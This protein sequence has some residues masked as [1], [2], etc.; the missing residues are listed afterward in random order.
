MGGATP[1]IS[2]IEKANFKIMAPHYQR[3]PVTTQEA[4]H[5]AEFFSKIDPKAPV[6]ARPAIDMAGT[7]LAGLFL[8][9]LTVFLRW[10]RS[11]R[12]RD[13]K[14]TRRRK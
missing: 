12:G 5:L 14:L 1:L 13:N 6:A 2:A 10:Q 11:T 8:A 9:G 3:H 4:I 7:G